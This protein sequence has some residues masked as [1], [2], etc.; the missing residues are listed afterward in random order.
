LGWD[1]AGASERNR[2]RSANRYI[3]RIQYGN[4][5][6]RL[7][8]SDLDRGGWMF[9]VVFDYGEGHYRD[10]ELD[11]ALPPDAQHRFARASLSAGGGWAVRPDPFS[12]H[13]AGWEV[14]TYRRCQ[15]VLMF[16]RFAELGAEPCL[17]RSTEFD[18]ADLN[19]SSAV[20]IETELEHQGSTRFGSFIRAATQSGY[21]SDASRAV[22]VDGDAR[23]VTYLKKS[24]PPLE[25]EYSRAAI[26]DTV[27]ELD[28]A[29][30]ENLPPGWTAPWQW[31]DLDGEG[32]VGRPHRT[33]R[34]LVLQA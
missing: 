17:V 27:R 26:Q 20:T 2:V 32:P 12:V 30:L 14:R 8:E 1:R 3:K 13:R 15:R 6:S 18:Y 28:T 24:L 22:V 34:R 7:V 31:V 11:G 25:L 21:V 19:Y 10:L 33:G 9:E 4:R 16:H 5:V 29:S 23:Y